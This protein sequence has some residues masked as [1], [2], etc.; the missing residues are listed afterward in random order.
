MVSG[1]G[2]KIDTSTQVS[3]DDKN[4]L[5]DL[6]QRLNEL[7]KLQKK[8]DEITLLKEFKTLQICQVKPKYF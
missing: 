5:K 2:S 6:L 7:R 4:K 3:T 8:N 1:Q